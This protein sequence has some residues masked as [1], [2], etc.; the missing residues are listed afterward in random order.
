MRRE[1]IK[2]FVT[3]AEQQAIKQW[4]DESLVSGKW[5]Y[6]GLSRGQWGYEVRKTT[7][8]QTQVKFPKEMYAI[9]DRL[10]KRLKLTN[11]C[12]LEATVQG[13]G[14]IAVATMAGGDTYAHKDPSPVPGHTVIRFNCVIQAAQEGGV[15]HV[16]DETGTDI[17][18]QLEEREM[19]LYNVHDFTHYVTEV[20]G[21]RPRYIILM[22]I[23]CPSDDWEKGIIKLC[24]CDNCA[25]AKV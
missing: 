16:V 21:D 5:L 17:E 9:R 4:F 10:L 7:R 11:N 13:D 24:T 8:Q 12:K 1:S 20:K 19:H 3:E 22:S 18:W 25:C 15:L 23:T 6:P 14:M 2:G